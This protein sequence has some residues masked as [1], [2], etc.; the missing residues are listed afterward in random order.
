MQSSILDVGKVFQIR[1]W[2]IYT[3]NK[4]TKQLSLKIKLV[5]NY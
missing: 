5:L 1:P 3:L 2:F 4:K